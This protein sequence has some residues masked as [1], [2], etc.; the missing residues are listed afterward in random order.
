VDDKPQLKKHID[1][2]NN[3]FLTGCITISHAKMTLSSEIGKNGLK[4]FSGLSWGR[5][6][7]IWETSKMEI[8]SLPL[9]F[10]ELSIL[11]G[12]GN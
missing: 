5:C 10:K 7:P 2:L 4:H 1:C 8:I 6:K 12:N 9:E 11:C 3:V